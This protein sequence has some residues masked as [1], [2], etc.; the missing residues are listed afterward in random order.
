MV[1]S[2]KVVLVLS[3]TAPFPNEKM[4]R[5]PT[6]LQMPL[7]QGIHWPLSQAAVEKDWS[8]QGSLV[9]EVTHITK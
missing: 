7:K 5:K 3:L 9:E 1:C 4:C 2:L 6:S 8:I